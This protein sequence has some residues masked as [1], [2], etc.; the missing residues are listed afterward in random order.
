MILIFHSHFF[1]STHK[2]FHLGYN[3]LILLY[4]VSPLREIQYCQSAVFSLGDSWSKVYFSVK[5]SLAYNPPAHIPPE[6][7]QGATVQVI[8]IWNHHHMYEFLAAENRV[9]FSMQKRKVWV[10]LE[11]CCRVKDRSKSWPDWAKKKSQ[12]VLLMAEKSTK[13]VLSLFCP[14]GTVKSTQ[15]ESMEE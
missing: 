6:N 5:K 15:P 10:S 7:E 11:F 12:V 2:I 13:L 4:F 8:L 3:F 1:C 9:F 14:R